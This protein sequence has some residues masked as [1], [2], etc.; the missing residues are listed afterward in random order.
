MAADGGGSLHDLMVQTWVMYGIG[1]A[2]YFLRMYVMLR[3]SCC[4][5]W[6]WHLTRP[7]MRDS[8]AWAG[9]GRPKILSC[10]RE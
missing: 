7:D 5:W 9:Y 4:P 2:L 8:N 3:F 6:H 10:F 1:V